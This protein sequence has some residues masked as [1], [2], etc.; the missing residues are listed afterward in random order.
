MTDLFI[1]KVIR[2]EIDNIDATDSEKDLIYQLLDIE[3][4]L[5]N[6]NKTQYMKDYRKAVENAAGAGY[7]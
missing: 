7:R 3:R 5:S 2:D 4:R 6:N 1:N